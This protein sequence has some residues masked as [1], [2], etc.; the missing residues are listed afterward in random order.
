MKD[1]VCPQNHR[2]RLL[3]NMYGIFCTT[4]GCSRNHKAVIRCLD[5][6]YRIGG[7]FGT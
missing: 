4:D 7:L 1:D 3:T 2:E 5:K 6:D